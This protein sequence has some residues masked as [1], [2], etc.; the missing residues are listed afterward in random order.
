MGAT[1]DFDGINSTYTLQKV[2]LRS[3]ENSLNFSRYGTTKFFS[4]AA[5]RNSVNFQYISQTLTD[6]N[7]ECKFRVV[8]A[9]SF[10]CGSH[11]FI[12]FFLLFCCG[13]LFLV[14]AAFFKTFFDIFFIFFW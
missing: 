3:S 14:D 5:D 1:Q 7:E 11:I 2:S 6:S 10:G 8:R 13:S 12:V 4:G 9:K